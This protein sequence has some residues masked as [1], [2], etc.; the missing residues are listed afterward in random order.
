MIVLT[1][2]FPLNLVIHTVLTRWIVF[3]VLPGKNLLPGHLSALFLLHL[4][5]IVD[6]MQI[7]VLELDPNLV[8]GEGGG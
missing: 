6:W 2:E 3:E 8:G 7:K 5:V 1:A 4:Q